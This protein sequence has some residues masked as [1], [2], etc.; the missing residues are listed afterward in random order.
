M[1]PDISEAEIKAVFTDDGGKLARQLHAHLYAG[2]KDNSN[3]N[4]TVDPLI[5]KL[6]PD[7]LL[8][9]SGFK[10]WD[11][12]ILK[13]WARHRPEWQGRLK[14]LKA[15]TYWKSR[16]PETRHAVLWWLEETLPE[17]LEQAFP[18]NQLRGQAGVRALSGVQACPARASRMACMGGTALSLMVIR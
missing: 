14:Q 4:T 12:V 9:S 1:N 15:L 13:D 6:A 10:H 7:S 8:Y 11:Q 3:L 17:W 2:F 18:G 5:E 16:F